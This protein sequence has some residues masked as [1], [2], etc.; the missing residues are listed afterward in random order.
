MMTKHSLAIGH[1]ILIRVMFILMFKVPILARAEVRLPAVFSDQMV[2]QRDIDV[3]VWGWADPGEEVTVTFGGESAKTIANNDGRWRVYLDKLL[4]NARSQ[5]LTVS[6][7][8]TVI[9]TNVLVGD[10]W[11]CSGQSN[12]GLYLG[13]CDNASS[14]VPKAND[15]LFRMLTVEDRTSVIPEVDATLWNGK[16]WRTCTPEVANQ[17][18]GVG[19]FFGKELRRHLG[20]PIG[21]ISS[22]KGGS[23]VQLWTSLESV[24]R[25]IAADP[26]F[27][28]WLEKREAVL[29]NYP[30]K[31][32]EYLP[33]KRHY[34]ADMTRYWNEVE[35]APELMARRK[36]WE[37][38][39]KL[40]REQGRIPP[41]RPEPA[42]PSPTAPEAP[43][44]GPYNSFMVGNLYN[45]MIAPLMPFAI[46]GVIWYQGES[47]CNNSKQYQT[48][49]PIMIKDW[50]EKWGQGNFPFLFVQLPNINKP[51]VDPVQDEDLWPGIREAQA[52]AL[53]LPNTGMATIID[54]GD[55]DEVHCK[56]KQD[57]G[58]RLSLIARNLVYKEN[59]VSSGPTYASMAIEANS[60]VLTF[61]NT[62]SGLTIGVPPWTPSG[63]IP[64]VASELTGFAIAGP[65]KQ[66]FKA[67]AMIIGSSQ[68]VVSSGRVLHPEAVRYAWADNPP[69]NLYNKERLPAAPFRTD[70]WDSLKRWQT[71]RN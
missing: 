27:K 47:N 55:P 64:P 22:L 12:M 25:N 40:A 54:V 17:F 23:Q 26:D 1:V 20:I 44:C 68:I 35:N 59:I 8:N 16:R 30:H 52:M 14:E 62:G 29:D 53:S 2:L 3:P 18:S 7:N 70:N 48:L 31:L 66:W 6:G 11:V 58:V 9:F 56:D 10:V 33:L 4:A 71:T 13:E 69:C 61:T 51:A 57:V 5:T 46:K 41:K 38:E 15:P 50:R 67:Q 28:G 34:D 65:D 60:I 37:N 49:F 45:A 24:K 32:S 36:L 43:D 39:C 42:E 63:T 19:Y 21:L